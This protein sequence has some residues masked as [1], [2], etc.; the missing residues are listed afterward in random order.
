MHFALAASISASVHGTVGCSPG[1]GGGGGFIGAATGVVCLSGFR[2]GSGGASPSALAARTGTQAQSA[3][4]ARSRS[5]IPVRSKIIRAPRRTACGFQDWM[6]AARH[7]TRGYTNSVKGNISLG[8][9]A[10]HRVQR[11][12][13][14][15]HRNAE[16]ALSIKRTQSRNVRSPKRAVPGLGAKSAHLWRGDGVDPSNRVLQR[17][18]SQGL[19][20]I[21]RAGRARYHPRLLPR[22][23]LALL[24]A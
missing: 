20:R 10:W 11:A 3:T 5:L 17:R 6:L 8:R 4:R 2:S 14:R 24:G 19:A 18:R 16:P 22:R 1:S 13:S 7:P 15:G 12:R 23:L 9:A 21:D